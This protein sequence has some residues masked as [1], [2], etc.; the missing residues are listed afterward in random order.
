MRIAWLADLDLPPGGGAIVDVP[1]CGA[2]SRWAI[3]AGEL[4]GA[5][6]AQE[7]RRGTVAHR[8]QTLIVRAL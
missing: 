5:V 3:I 6:V 2:S 7:E 1:R 4:P 8:M